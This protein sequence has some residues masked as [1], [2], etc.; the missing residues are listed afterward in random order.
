VWH[1]P[2]K[3]VTWFSRAIVALTLALLAISAFLASLTNAQLDAW[4]IPEGVRESAKLIK[5][6]SMVI[7]MLVPAVLMWKP[8]ERKLTRRMA[9][10]ADRS[11]YPVALT[12]TQDGIDTGSDMGVVSFSDSRLRVEGLRTSF[13]IGNADVSSEP[14]I[15]YG[16]KGLTFGLK[17]A[18][19]MREVRVVLSSEGS[20][21][22]N[23]PYRLAEELS[24]WHKH[25]VKETGG[26]VPLQFQH[27]PAPVLV[28]VV[29]T[30][31]TLLI[32][33]F[34]LLS[35]LTVGAKSLWL[36]ALFAA[37]GLGIVYAACIT[38]WKEIHSQL[39]RGALYEA[40]SRDM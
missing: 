30:S 7:A 16:T 35:V 28:I 29:L 9:D 23:R 21:G 3:S 15:S 4:A 11:A 10:E 32:A 36:G 12:V 13:T 19:T 22:G 33:Y 34:V 8:V 5:G 25:P 1:P 18:H 26:G 24:E 14:D 38:F 39:K 37:L 40:V 27:E 17:L 20:V 2:P 6:F 31:F